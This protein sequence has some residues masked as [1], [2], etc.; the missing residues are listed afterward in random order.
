MNVQTNLLS[1]IQSNQLENIH[2]LELK[3]PLLKLPLDIIKQIFS[4]LDNRQD[5]RLRRVCK[6]WNQ[7]ALD[8]HLAARLD[9]RQW[10]S[11]Y[12]K[13]R[14]HVNVIK[15]FVKFK[16][17]TFM[18]LHGANVI[19]NNH[20]DDYSYSN[21]CLILNQPCFQFPS[22]LKSYLNWACELHLDLVVCRML[23]FEQFDPSIDDNYLIRQAS[24]LGCLKIVLALLNDKRVDPSAKN[25]ESLHYAIQNGHHEI[26]RL[27]LMDERIDKQ[28]I[29]QQTY[30]WESA[31]KEGY[32]EMIKAFL[33]H[34]DIDP[35]TNNQFPL[36]CAC[37]YGKLQVI[38]QLLQDPRVDISAN[39]Y[40]AIKLASRYGHEEV[41]IFLSSLIRN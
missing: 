14:T 31:I 11:L 29:N 24:K 25:C 15:Q 12:V 35:S 8:M 4:H 27:L 13:N 3:T 2:E 30:F 39:Y 6:H 37:H 17:A 21:I 20:R 34:T 16:T 33:E 19:E 22:F 9:D 32:V 28:F 36:I 41:V 38:E 26:V 7:A 5:Y 18:V 10:M 1:K 40:E 23:K